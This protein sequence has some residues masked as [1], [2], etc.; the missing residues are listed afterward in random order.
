MNGS[1]DIAIAEWPSYRRT[2]IRQPVAAMVTETAY[3]LRRRLAGEP[4]RPSVMLIP[5]TLVERGSTRDR[6]TTG[7]TAG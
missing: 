4:A 7:E 2:T 3:L 6:S 5:G 1:D